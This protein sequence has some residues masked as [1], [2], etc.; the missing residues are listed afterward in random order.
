MK[1]TPVTSSL[2]A[3]VGYDAAQETIEVE[4]QNGRIYQYFDVEESEMREL[5]EADSLGA[6]FNANIRGGVSV[7]Q[8]TVMADRRG[9]GGVPNPASHR[10]VRHVPPLV[11]L[12]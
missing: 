2:I 8:A 1:R 9:I 6:Y 12:A 10:L 3:S 11:S 7:C 4:F 5:L